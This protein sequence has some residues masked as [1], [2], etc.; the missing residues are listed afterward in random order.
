ML[1]LF[2]INIDWGMKRLIIGGPPST[3]SSLLLRI[4]LRHSV[5]V[6]HA[7]ETHMFTKL[8]LYQDWNHYKNRFLSKGSL[9]LRSPGWHLYNGVNL[10]TNS[11]DKI[12]QIIEQSMTFQDF[13]DRYFSLFLKN[14]IQTIW[15]EKTPANSYAFDLFRS[16]FENSFAIMTIR[17]PYDTIASLVSRGLSI[18]NAVGIVLCNTIGADYSSVIVSYENLVSDPENA[19]TKLANRIDI[20]YEDQ[21]LSPDQDDEQMTGWLQSEGGVISNLSQNRF[22]ELDI[23]QQNLIL[24]YCQSIYVNK[25]NN[26]HAKHEINTIDDICDRWNYPKRNPK[27]L[28]KIN[29]KA[30]ILNDKLQRTRRGYPTHFLNYPITIGNGS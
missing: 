5:I 17:D 16:N 9:G 26:L 1:F 27:T 15:I 22:D 10:H 24:N 30:E 14:K 4:L 23:H 11:I 2:R 21:M 7:D 8:K 20:E 28:I 18:F 29:I 19:I 25:K 6:G 13:A 3:G 12:Q